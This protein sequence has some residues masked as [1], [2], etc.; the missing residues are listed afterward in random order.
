[1]RMLSLFCLFVLCG[2][3]SAQDL[4]AAEN[5]TARKA[6]FHGFRPRARVDG[7]GTVHLVQMNREKRGDLFYTK[8]AAG[9]GEWSPPLQVNRIPG[10]V[11]AFTFV[12]GKDG[13]VH[14]MFRPTP[15]FSGRN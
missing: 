12:V 13:R 1:M 14:V 9:K 11:A 5:V 15:V 4:P 6:P 10:A 8:L 3:G 7:D 2:P